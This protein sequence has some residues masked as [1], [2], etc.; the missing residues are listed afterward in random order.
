MTSDTE[1]LVSPHTSSHRMRPQAS[2]TLASNLQ[3][4]V[5]INSFV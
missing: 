4:L 3:V 2:R 5:S 1:Q